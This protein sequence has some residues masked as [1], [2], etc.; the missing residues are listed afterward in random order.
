MV[1]ESSSAAPASAAAARR[2]RS[3]SGLRYR[4]QSTSGRRRDQGRMRFSDDE[5]AVIV[6]AATREGWEANPWVQMV[7]YERAVQL[8]DSRD[9]VTSSAVLKEFRELRRLL[10]N[11][12]GNVNDLA[13]AAN[14]TGELQSH[15]ML[16]AVMRVLV[17]R[18]RVVDSAVAKL[19]GK[20]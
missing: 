16:Q 12:G 3:H 2:V 18:V 14:S 11:I 15:E 8:R 7:A 4:D 9:G 5:W 1:D 19:L 17:Q 20:S 10:T 13:R 6:V